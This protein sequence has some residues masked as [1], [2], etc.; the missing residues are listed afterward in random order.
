MIIAA[1]FKANLTRVA[2]K[3]YIETLESFLVQNALMQDVLVFPP[4]SALLKHSGKVVV[5]SQNAYPAQNGAYTGEITKEQLDEFGITT[6]LLGHS[7]RRELMMESDDMLKKKFDFFATLGYK[8]LFCIGESLELR[9]TS[10]DSVIEH[11]SNQLSY[12]DVTYKNLII[13]YEPIWAIG[14]GLVPTLDE[15]HSTHKELRKL[16]KAPLLYGGSVKV[17]NIEDILN[18]QNVDGVLVGGASLK[19]EAFAKMCQ[20]AQN[21]NK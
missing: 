10:L 16:S 20:I 5:G 18:I 8:I 15:I 4:S 14:S 6:V 3:E 11:L 19:V 12:I 21:I 9:K 7:E 13:A 1:N 17:E 2:T